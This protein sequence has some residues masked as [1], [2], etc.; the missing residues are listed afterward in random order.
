MKKKKIL[1]FGNTAPLFEEFWV[2]KMKLHFLR[3]RKLKF[4]YERADMKQYQLPAPL[5]KNISLSIC[6]A[7]CPSLHPSFLPTFHFRVTL[8]PVMSNH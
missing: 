8:A 2:Q 4:Q 3:K 5:L 6:P 1:F 7:I